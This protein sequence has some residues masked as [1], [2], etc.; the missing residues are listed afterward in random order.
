VE[1]KTGK[2]PTDRAKKG[3]KRSL[4]TDGRGVPVGV[5][6]A[7]AN[8]PDYQLAEETIESIPVPRPEP[9]VP[10]TP[11][12]PQAGQEQGLCLDAG[13]FYEEIYALLERWGYTAHIRPVG[14]GSGVRDLTAAEAKA[15]A[16][17]ARRWVA[18]RTHSWL[19][20]FRGLLIRWCKKPENYL[21]MLHFAC[22]LITHRV[23][24]LLG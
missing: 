1:K 24:A 3:T 4:L 20:R 15:A 12:A 19:N 13:Y 16:I 6:V 17:L 14:S 11:E 8:V 9:R 22:A 2:N 7:G 18:E 5:A 21:A 10:S 23:T